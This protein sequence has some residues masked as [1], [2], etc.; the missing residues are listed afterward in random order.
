MPLYI[1]RFRRV[2]HTYPDCRAIRA[3]AHGLAATYADTPNS[4][5]ARIVEIPDPTISAELE[6]IRDFTSPCVFCVSGARESWRSLP[7]IF[8]QPEERDSGM[9]WRSAAVVV[10][11]EAAP[12]H[13]GLV[14]VIGRSGDGR[15]VIV[16]EACPEGYVIG[17]LVDTGPFEEDAEGS[18]S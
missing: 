14:R 6:A 17:A 15:E 18:G 5:P 2:R 1:N 11:N 9:D 8:E 7:I 16:E 3:S 12:S 10:R 4:P 13:P